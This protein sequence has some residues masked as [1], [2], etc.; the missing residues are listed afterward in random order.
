MT[1]TTSGNRDEIKRFL[2][3]SEGRLQHLQS[4]RVKKCIDFNPGK[5]PGR[6]HSANIQTQ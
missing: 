4:E 5:L 3:Y 2:D 6:R 1:D